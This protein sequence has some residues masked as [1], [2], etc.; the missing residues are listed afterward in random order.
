MSSSPIVS[1]ADRTVSGHPSFPTGRTGRPASN[2]I[3][4][5]QVVSAARAL[6]LVAGV[7]TLLIVCLVSLRFGSRDVSSHDAWNA[8]FNF[9]P[10]S[11]NQGVVR[12]LRIPRTVIALA[13]GG[14]FAVAGATLQ[15]ATRNP[16][17]EPSILGV[18]S[19]ASFAVV[20]AIYL[21]HLTNPNEYLWFGFAGAMAA[22]VLVF[23]IGSAGREGPTPTK[24]ALAGIVV[25]ALL[26]AWTNALLL[27]DEQTFDL[28]RFWF[29][30]SVVG[31]DLD[32]LWMV[33][34]FLAGGTIACLL[35]G[36]QLNV[37]GLGDEAAQSLGMNARRTRFFC[38]GVV[39]II[40]GAGVAVAGPIAYIGLAVPHMIRAVVG[41][42]YRWILPYC[43]IWGAVF[44]VLA[45]VIGRLAVR[46]SEI[47]VGVVTA[48]FGAPFLVILARRRGVAG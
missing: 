1:T 12:S 42:D 48:L 39:V 33:L 8:I 36:H 4:Q 13:I 25:S 26:G 7:A 22:S 3:P 47:E 23:F 46:P 31:R 30:G 45:D 16:L 17:A 40:V 41:T 18:T 19:G 44:L 15:G 38:M 14:A 24:L 34:P 35:L 28:V 21:L 29:A 32:T 43:L 5:R 20:T 6:G 11:A 10:A 2:G 37:L 27:L 9:D